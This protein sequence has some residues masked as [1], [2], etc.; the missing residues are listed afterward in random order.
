MCSQELRAAGYAE[1]FLIFWQS[2][3]PI[4]PWPGKDMRSSLCGR[5]IYAIAAIF[6]EKLQNYTAVVID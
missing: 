5:C 2:E 1:R 3:S 6:Q 4:V